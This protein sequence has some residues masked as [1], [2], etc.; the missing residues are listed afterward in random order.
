MRIVSGISSRWPRRSFKRARPV[1]ETVQPLDDLQNKIVR[2]ARH[3]MRSRPAREKT[4]Q[5]MLE[6]PHLVSE[7][8]DAQLRVRAIL[9]SARLM[10]RPDG[11]RLLERV[12]GGRVRMVYVTDRVLQYV[13]E[14][15]T[16]QGLVAVVDWAAPEWESLNA[17]PLLVADEIQDP[18]N[19]GT[20]IRSAASFGFAVGLTTGSASPSNPKAIRAT[21]GAVFQ[22][23]VGRLAD[24]LKWPAGLKVVVA[25]PRSSRPYYDWDWTAPTALVVGNEGSGVG[26]RW[27]TQADASLSIPMADGRESL[28][29]AVA[30]SIMMAYAY[31]KQSEP[32]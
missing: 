11:P 23:P 16:H 27:L 7:A 2:T 10:E 4:G 24:T 20:L 5:I 32:R 6:G 26:A 18:G 1:L 19:L 28:N 8:L 14:V 30:G 17:M 21:A 31:R 9:Y 29:A 13:S 25:D 12:T 3:L 15:E 22:T